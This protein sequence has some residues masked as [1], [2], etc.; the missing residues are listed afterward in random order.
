LFFTDTT[1]PKQKVQ[2]LTIDF[3]TAGFTPG[4]VVHFSYDVS[5]GFIYI[6][7]NIQLFAY[8]SFMRSFL[9]GIIN[10]SG[11]KLPKECDG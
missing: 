9:N 3:Y 10:V 8:Y 4:A 5:K 2:D 1:P 7:F 11:P 6:P